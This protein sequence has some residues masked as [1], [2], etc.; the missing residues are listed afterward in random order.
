MAAGTDSRTPSCAG[1]GSSP[2]RPPPSWWPSP[3][4]RPA[5]NWTPV[6]ARAIPKDKSSR[7]VADAI[8][9][10]FGGAGESPVTVAVSASS[11]Q[12]AAVGAFADRIR[13][14]GDVRSVGGARQP[15]PR[16][17]AGDGRRPRRRR[18]VT[19]RSNV[20]HEIRALDPQFPAAVAGPAAEFVDQQAAIASRLP[21]ALL[22][23]GGL[24]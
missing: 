9:R 1:P 5:S 4:R 7:T 2:S 13:G 17:L 24:T 11:A 19:G 23:L 22:L 10:D 12:A 15:R 6:D 14:L 16:H 8:E 3:R 21:A 20:V 18:P